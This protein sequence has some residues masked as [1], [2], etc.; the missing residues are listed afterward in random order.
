MIFV[1][2]DYASPWSYLASELVERKLPGEV[3]DWRPIYLRGLPMFRE[4]MPYTGS[5]LRYMG[6]DLMRCAAHEGV[7]FR[8]P[9]I[10]PV[11]GLHAVRGAIAARAISDEAFSVYHRAMFRAAWSQD[12][13][14][15]RRE[16][17]VEIAVE[18]GLD[19]ARFT[20]LVDAPETKDKLRAETAAA[21]AR[22]VFGVPAFFVGRTEGDAELFWGHDRLDYVA[23]AAAALR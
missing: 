17:V 4:G 7:P 21:E 12:R 11:N 22:G 8:F 3:V 18:A 10:F 16:V 23:R 6:L 13:D 9:S 15:G 19:R 14:I 5:K 2:Y 20:S 1:Y